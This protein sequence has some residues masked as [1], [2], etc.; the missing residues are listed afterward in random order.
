MIII[1]QKSI[2]EYEE[3][4]MKQR[5]SLGSCKSLIFSYNELIGNDTES[6]NEITKYFDSKWDEFESNWTEWNNQD[7]ITWF[8][9]KVMQISLDNVH[10]R[11]DWNT[12]RI[13][14][15]Y[16]YV[17][18]EALK[19]FDHSTFESIGIKGFDTITYLLQEINTLFNK[20]PRNDENMI[21]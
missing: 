5:S 3:K 2:K 20:Y 9:Y 15:K 21:S 16:K 8:Q 10:I 18:A 13:Q 1:T 4:L 14:L 6:I 19:N 11:I 12:T 17:T 7:M